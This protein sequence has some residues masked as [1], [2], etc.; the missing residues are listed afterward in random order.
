MYEIIGLGL[1]GCFIATIL[2]IVVH[3]VG[4]NAIGYIFDTHSRETRK[5][6]W[7]GRVS[8]SEDWFFLLIGGSLFGAM[9]AFV[10]PATITVVLLYSLMV[11]AR[12]IVRSSKK[13]MQDHVAT[14]H[15]SN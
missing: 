2:V 3:D 7:V 8:N 11:L 10:W 9:L 4:V 15:N 5:K 12:R 1:Y 6:R 14:L 13:V